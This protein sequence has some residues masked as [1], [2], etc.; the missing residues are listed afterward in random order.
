[1]KQIGFTLMLIV[2][3]LS[4]LAAA[5]QVLPDSPGPVAS[6]A[7]GASAA[8]LPQAPAP[9]GSSSSTTGLQ[10][11]AASQSTL[12]APPPA[13]SGPPNGDWRKIQRLAHGEQIVVTST[14]GPSQACRFAG[15]TDDALFCD[16]PGA[17][18]GSGYRFERGTVISVQATRPAYNYHP[19]WIAA[20]IGGGLTVGII[21]AQSNDAGDAAKIGAVGALVVGA[22]GAP[23]ALLQPHSGG[24]AV[25][26]P[27]ALRFGGR[28]PLGLR[29][30]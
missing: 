1:M 19:A 24:V 27:H 29:P 15:A 3:V 20:V 5:C 4:P 2:I 10:E 9:S 7:A 8:D 12:Q 26:R 22:I 6:F 23:L 11:T 21:A 13:K 16:A 30:R 17:P 14:Y 28:G 25:Y 18:D